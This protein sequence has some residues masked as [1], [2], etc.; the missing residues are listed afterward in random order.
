MLKKP[1]LRKKA[2]TMT[3]ALAFV[4]VMIAFALMISPVRASPITVSV[5]PTSGTPGTSVLVSGD[6]ATPHGEVR[7]YL[8]VFF[9]SF[10]ME[11]T[12]ADGAGMY[13]VNI[14]VPAINSG[15]YSILALDVSADDDASTPFTIETK[16]EIDPTEGS[17][18]DQAIVKG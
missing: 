11:T 4:S 1:L 2:N 9:V 6:D 12:T 17:G 7:I 3:F 5:S 10:F 14:T 18:N 8:S 13:S 15:S 16:I